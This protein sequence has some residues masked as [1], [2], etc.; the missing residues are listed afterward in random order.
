[1][2]MSSTAE[3]VYFCA[4]PAP[5]SKNI[6]YGSSLDHFHLILVLYEKIALNGTFTFLTIL[7]ENKYIKENLAICQYKDLI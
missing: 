6:S 4:A 2:I 1:M 7:M 3:L 5:A